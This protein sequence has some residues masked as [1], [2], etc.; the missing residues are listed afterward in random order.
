MYLIIIKGDIFS[1]N[2]NCFLKKDSPL[3]NKLKR[4]RRR[5]PRRELAT[6]WIELGKSG[7]SGNC[8]LDFKQPKEKQSIC[9]YLFKE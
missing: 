2:R 9:K 1:L 8:I 6:L 3:K 7:C 5:S 4:P